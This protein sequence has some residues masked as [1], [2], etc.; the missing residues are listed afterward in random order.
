MSKAR[1]LLM[2]RFTRRTKDADRPHRG[3]LPT[4]SNHDSPH[5]SRP[6]RPYARSSGSTPKVGRC[7]GR[8][9]RHQARPQ[10]NPRILQTQSCIG[11]LQYL[12]ATVLHRQPINSSVSLAGCFRIKRQRCFVTQTEQ[13]KRWMGDDH[14]YGGDEDYDCDYDGNDNDDDADDDDDETRD[15]WTDG[16]TTGWLG[17][18]MDGHAMHAHELNHSCLCFHLL[19]YHVG[20][21]M[22]SLEIFSLASSSE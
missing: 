11:I 1:R 12:V 9:C 5:H 22:R 13:I 10:V 17:G 8:P 14:D 16:W 19:L 3:P 2:L 18:W 6:L 7:S 21:L 20:A 4:R 15:G